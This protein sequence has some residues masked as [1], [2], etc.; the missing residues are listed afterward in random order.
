LIGLNTVRILTGEVP[1][2]AYVRRVFET[3]LYPLATAPAG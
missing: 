2:R 3:V 1:D